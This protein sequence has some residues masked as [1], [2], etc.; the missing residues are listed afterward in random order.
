ML[1][2]ITDICS[3]LFQAQGTFVP[4]KV[5]AQERSTIMQRL[6]RL[7]QQRSLCTTLHRCRLCVQLSTVFAKHYTDKWTDR[8][9]SMPDNPEAK[10][11][12]PAFEYLTR[13]VSSSISALF[14]GMYASVDG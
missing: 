8:N 14:K 5:L 6:A 12:V 9:A 10:D 4:V 13:E 7:N 11:M 1:N 2:L 3:P